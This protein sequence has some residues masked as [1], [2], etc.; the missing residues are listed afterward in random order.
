MAYYSVKRESS[1]NVFC[2]DLSEPFKLTNREMKEKE[3]KCFMKFRQDHESNFI[4]V[5]NRSNERSETY[6]TEVIRLNIK[7]N[8]EIDDHID[9]QH[10]DFVDDE[11]SEMMISQEDNVTIYT[12][13]KEKL[14]TKWKKNL[15]LQEKLFHKYKRES[16]SYFYMNQCVAR[17]LN[18]EEPEEFSTNWWNQVTPSIEH[19]LDMGITGYRIRMNLTTPPSSREESSTEEEEEEG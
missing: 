16:Q 9:L 19:E 6:S 11:N 8:K 17:Q 18:L 15:E 1:L 14:L 2:K 4:I 3:L 7:I 5:N 10:S 12:W 13:M